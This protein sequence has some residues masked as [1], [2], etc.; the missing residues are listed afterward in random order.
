MKFSVNWPG[1]EEE[2]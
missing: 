1:F 2:P